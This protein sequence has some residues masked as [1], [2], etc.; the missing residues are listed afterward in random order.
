MRNSDQ[1]LSVN[2]GD[3]YSAGHE[4][5]KNGLLRQDLLL[6]TAQLIERIWF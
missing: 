3:S 1:E 2:L 6:L 4:T 5:L